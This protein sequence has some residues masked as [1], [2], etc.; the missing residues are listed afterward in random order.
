VERSQA[1]TRRTSLAELDDEFDREFWA[2][3]TPSEKLEETWRLSEELW[4]FSGR[5][6]GETGLSRSVARVLRR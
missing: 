5:S 2:R 6:S 1:V 4:R 3:F